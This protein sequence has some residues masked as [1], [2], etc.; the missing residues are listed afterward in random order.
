MDKMSKSGQD[1]T[2]AIVITVIVFL[3]SAAAFHQ[4][5]YIT[6]LAEIDSLKAQRTSKEQT[7]NNYKKV[8]EE[9]PNF[10][11][12]LV[13]LHATWDNNKHYFVNGMVDW[14]DIE[15][16]RQTQFTIFQLYE[17]VIEAAVFAGIEVEHPVEQE[18]AIMIT[19]E[20]QFHPDDEPF[21]FPPHFLFLVNNWSFIPSERFP[22]A[23]SEKGAADVGGSS[24]G[25]SGGF[26][27][28]TGGGS[29]ASA[30]GAVKNLFSAHDFT[31]EFEAT[32]DQLKKFI[33][34]MQDLEGDEAWVIS[35]HCFETS[36]DPIFFGF[37]ATLSGDI[38]YTDV[39]I[40]MEM[41]CTAYELYEPGATNIP[42]NLPGE[43]SCS[44]S[45]GGGGG[46]SSSG[47]GGIG[48]GGGAGFS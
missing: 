42:P 1:V 19:E 5:F 43:T 16:I 41:F 24:S 18:F 45:G 35:V 6:K 3:G 13:A 11:E 33:E 37:P 32:Y 34:I 30:G 48:G 31:V 29:S 7:F 40:P 12:Q 25:S 20:L 8:I 14:D 2:I 27:F 4:Y 21:D 47:G 39:K 9:K 28:G 38:V 46:G 17:K 10:E 15:E 36:G 26:G 44:P 23:D 22:D